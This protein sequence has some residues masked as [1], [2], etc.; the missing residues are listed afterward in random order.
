[1]VY[2][3]TPLFSTCVVLGQDTV[4]GKVLDK[5]TSKG[6]DF[7]AISVKNK[8]IG[9]Y[10]DFNGR[11]VLNG[12]SDTDTLVLVHVSYE[13]ENIP[14]AFFSYD[15]LIFITSKLV[16]LEE[17]IIKP[18]KRKE[19]SIGFAKGGSNSSFSTFKGY[20]IT[21]LIKDSK[22]TKAFVKEIS[23]Q[24]KEEKA[25][26][27]IK[28]HLYYNEN[29]KPGKEITHD[30]LHRIDNAKG[31]IRIDV[32]NSW[33]PF[34]EEGLFVGIEWAGMISDNKIDKVHNDVI[35]PRIVLTENSKESITY[36][37]FWD[38]PWMVFSP[39]FNKSKSTAAVGLTLFK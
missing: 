20:E 24:V 39:P 13:K 6:I 21:T 28:T 16:P 22:L 34:P 19:C 3:L 36:C 8:N 31:I 4:S 1:M 12:V 23:I 18:Q 14:V 17:V 15:S 38:M 25:C 37:R 7:V 30:N 32:S 9:T 10:T 35:C 33:I 27:Y 26:Y 11:F 29:G 2:I 5:Q